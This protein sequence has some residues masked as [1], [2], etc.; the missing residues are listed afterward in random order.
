VT[1]TR[2]GDLIR[3]T[4]RCRVEDAEPLTVL[5]QAAPD[6]TLEISGC[7]V[8]HAAVV[9]AILAFRPQLKGVSVDP[10]IS[11]WLSPRLGRT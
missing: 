2:D 7:E 5:L 8:L 9:Q 10:F 3:L 11:R 6:A 1:V 4:G